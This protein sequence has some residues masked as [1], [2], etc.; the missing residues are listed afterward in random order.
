MARRVIITGGSRGIGAACVRKFCKM[1]D[2]VVFI[3]R[4]RSEEATTLSK[5]TGALAIRADVS[6]ADELSRAIHSSIECLGGV[7]ILINN[8]GISSSGLLTDVT[9]EEWNRIIS[10]NLSSVYRTSRA[11]IPFMVHQKSGSILNIGS[12]WGKVGASCEVAYSASKAGV[13]GFTMALAKELGPSGIRVNC[14]E[15]GVI[16]TEMNAGLDK[17]S[18]KQLSEET[19]LGR[20]GEPEDIANAAFFLSSEEASFITGQI[21]GVDGGFAIG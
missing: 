18:L 20:I 9:E 1:G 11:V 10:T 12:M 2:R 16:R 19:P 17:E 6:D 8:A 21:I 15:P 13:R 7:N 4:S 5:E 3:Y 14:I